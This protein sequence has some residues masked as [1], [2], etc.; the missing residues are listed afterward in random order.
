M[1]FVKSAHTRSKLRG[2][3]RKQTKDTDA[4]RGKE[5]LEKELRSLGLDPKQYLGEEK[6]RVVADQLDTCETAQDVLAKVGSGLTSVQNVVQR[7]RGQTQEQPSAD[8]IS[9][10]KTKEGKLS[11]AGA[12]A[13]VLIQRAKCCSPIPGDE[14]VGYVTRGRGIMVHRRVCPNAMAFVTTEPD[15]LIPY[16]WPSDGN[17]YSV[18]LKILAVNRQG[19]LM[20]IST[21]FGETKTNVSA[22]KVKTL[23]NQTAE[24]EVTVDVQD[25]DHLAF[26]MTKISNYGDVFSIL[27]M[28]GRLGK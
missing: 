10:T 25:T 9:I 16:E 13:S 20:D 23:P 1:E 24:I 11:L 8:R 19:L 18:S 2:Y 15:R 3:F 21:I 17:V 26:L 4:H 12:G 14:V 7:L 28:F 22:M 6:L 5:L 27:R